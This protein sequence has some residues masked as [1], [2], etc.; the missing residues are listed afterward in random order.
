VN[1]NRTEW[2]DLSDR[3]F[4]LLGAT[5]AMGPLNFLLSHG[6]NIIAVDLNRDFIWKK[7]F[8]AVKNSNGTVIFPVKQGIGSIDKLSD[9]ELAKVSGCDLLSNTPEIANWLSTVVPDKQLTIGNYTYLDGALHVQLSLACDSIIDRLCQERKDTNIAFLC[10]P[11]DN[12]VVTKQAYDASKESLRSRVPLWATIINQIFCGKFLGSPNYK[13]MKSVDQSSGEPIYI[14]DGIAVAQGPNYALAKRLQHWR[15]VIAFCNGHT[16][17]SNVAPSTAT[18]SVVHNAQFA[19]AYGGMHYFEPMEV[20][21][22]RTSLAVMGTLLI[23]DISNKE[24]AANPNSKIAKK[25]RNPFELFSY[26][27]FHGGVWRCS[28]KINSIGVPSAVSYYLKTYKVAVMIGTSS[29][30][31]TGNWLLTGNLL[32]F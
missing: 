31:A 9:D 6:A 1:T 17:S 12:H 14:I 3:Y 18:M 23:H 7:I 13:S 10:T 20:M 16:V 22:Q 4:V 27:S 26:G 30:I 8:N 15:A 11:T 21:Y 28:Y 29:L 2:L 25:F 24:G 5:S 19:A 32:P